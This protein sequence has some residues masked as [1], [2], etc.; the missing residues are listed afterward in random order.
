M[1]WAKENVFSTFHICWGA[2]AGLYHHYGIP[3][4]PLREKKFGVFRHRVLHSQNKLVRG[5]DDEFLAPHSRHTEIRRSDI[6]KK[7]RLTILAESDE[8][9]VYIIVSNDGRHIFITGHSEYDPLT[10]K[11]E[12]DR[13]VEKSWRLISLPIIIPEM[14]WRVSQESIGEDMPTCC[15]RTG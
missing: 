2:Q 9:G 10:L 4:H 6:D 13:D 7:P 3:K 12:Y 5:F 11:T 8:A 15:F 14:T 1:E